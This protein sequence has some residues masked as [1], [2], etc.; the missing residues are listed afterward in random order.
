MR[1]KQIVGHVDD[2]RKKKNRPMSRRG[3]D[4]QAGGVLLP[5]EKLEGGG[6]KRRGKDHALVDYCKGGTDLGE[7]TMDALIKG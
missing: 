7:K 3:R 4:T 1:K 5:L 6:P 2:E